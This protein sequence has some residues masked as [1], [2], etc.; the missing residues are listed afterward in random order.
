MAGVN[1]FGNRSDFFNSLNKESFQKQWKEFQEFRDEYKE[2]ERKRNLL[3]QNID[4]TM[5]GG[6]R[7]ANLKEYRNIY[8]INAEDSLDA[9]FPFYIHFNIV[10]EMIKI[11][12]IQLS[13]W[14]LNFRAYAKSA[15]S[16]GAVSSASGGGETPT[17]SSGGGETP[18]S[19]SGGEVTSAS[20][21]GQTPTSSSGGAQTSGSGGGQTS[22]AGG[23]QTS[24]V[25]GNTHEHSIT[26][27]DG[28]TS[29]PI[30]YSGALWDIKCAGG[31]T[32]T[33]GH[34]SSNHTHTVN[35]HTHTVADHTHSVADHTHTVTIAA[36]THVG[37]AHTHT[38]TTSNHTHTVTI[39]AHTHTGGAHTHGITYGIYEDSTSATVMFCVSRDNGLTYS[40]PGG[41]YSG[42]QENLDITRFIDTAGSKM[43]KFTSNARTRL[44]V[45]ITIK[46]DIKV[47]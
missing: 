23:G 7:S 10:P 33:T 42:N 20:G 41:S 35:N 43:I 21:G 1:N 17:S 44:S 30:Y 28:T 6:L 5:R 46:L 3:L 27:G 15:S 22:G 16:G 14:F 2:N 8:V 38:V 26:L 40:L 32:I 4:D 9:D 36:H 29:V 24:S 13:F 39:A 18:T 31:G 45:Q 11:V 12:S 47:R 25:E 34:P 37:G 19:S